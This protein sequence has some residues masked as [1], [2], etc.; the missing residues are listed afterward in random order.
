[1]RCGQCGETIDPGARF[2]PACG[3]PV[4][5]GS[6]ATCGAAVA[7]GARFCAECGAPVAATSAPAAAADSGRERK[8]A[9]LLFADLVGFTALNETHDPEVIEA[10]VGR[11]FER[12]SAEVARYE[13]LVEKFAGDAML[14]VFGV[15]AVHE[16]DAERAVRA[17]FE[18]QGAMADLRA[19]LEAEGRPALA[20]RI[21]IETGEVLANRQRAASERDRI[22]T[23]DAVNT[24]ARLEQAALPGAVVVGPGTYAA[25]RE[26]IEYEELEPITLKG[27]AVPVPAWRAVRVKTGRLGGRRAVLGLEAPLIGRDEELALL[28]ETVRRTVA[29][30]RPHLVTVLGSAGV[31]KSR[32]TWELEKYLDGLPDV[33]HWRKGRCLAY[34]QRSYSALGDAIAADAS[35]LDDDP[36]EVVE[37]KLAARLEALSDGA[38]PEAVGVGARVVLGLSGAGGLPRDELFEAWRGYLELIARR[39]PL[40]LVLED[41]HWADEGLLDFIEF[42]ARWAEAPIMILCLARHELLERRPAWGGGLPNATSIVLEPLGP[43]ES[44]RLVGAPLGGPLPAALQRRVVEVTEGNPLFAEEL[45]RLFVD[46]GVVRHSEGRWEQALPVDQVEIPQSIQAL[47]AAR[48]DSLPAEEKRL[49]QDAAVVGRIF[50]DRLLA[51]LAGQSPAAMVGLLRSLRVKELVVPRE[52]SSL[53]DAQEYAF[54][55]VLIRDVAYDSLPKLERARKHREVAAWAEE[56]LG[57]RADEVVELLAAHYWSALRYEEEFS[58]D[59][60]AL[61]DLRRR[62]LDYARAAGHRALDVGQFESA[63]QWM[64]IVIEQSQKLETPVREHAE[65]VLDYL[66]VAELYETYEARLAVV[67]EVVEGLTALDVPEV[68]DRRRLAALREWQAYLLYSGTSQVEEVRATIAAGLEMLEGIGPCAERAA[69][70]H[71]LGWIAWRAGPGG[72][73]PQPLKQGN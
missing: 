50:W 72:P 12:L 36:T 14:A 34:A 18:M 39:A 66:Q 51:H 62:T 70:L 58:T 38:A 19:E 54:R 15:P 11:A 44:D 68:E 42:L 23:G 47:L 28:K 41:I 71:R 63:T 59:A 33:Y 31:G 26:T 10:V 56:R 45:V 29:E 30:G 17:A 43:E 9:T 52:P 24:A 5:E 6:C 21:G 57:E 65:L 69:L 35:A 8:V 25:T 40:V 4:A 32:L 20:L 53:T 73:A 7:A 61:A 22:V 16:D 48:L 49:S 37:S 46:R 3:T 13:G 2:C 1:M 27:K 67:S 64:R 60:A 55:H